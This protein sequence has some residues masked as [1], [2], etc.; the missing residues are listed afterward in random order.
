M[1]QVT[2]P[3]ISLPTHLPGGAPRGSRA[4]SRSWPPPRSRSCSRSAGAP[5]RT[6]AHSTPRLSRASAPAAV[7]RRA[8]WPRPSARARRAGR[9]RAARSIDLGR[10]TDPPE[11]ARGGPGLGQDEARALA[12]VA[13][14]HNPAVP[15]KRCLALAALALALAPAAHAAQPPPGW[16]PHVDSA[17]DYAGGRAGTV[18]FAVRT[19]HRVWGRDARRAVPAASVLKV[20]LL[21]AY[22]RRA[23]VRG[24]ALRPPT[25]RSSR[26]WCAG[27][28]TWP[29]RGCAAS[30]ATPASCGSPA[31][32]ECAASARHAGLGPLERRR[33]RSE[34]LP[35][36]RRAAGAAAPPAHRPAACSARSCPRSAGGSRACAAPDGRSTSRAAGAR[37][38]ARWTTRWR[39]CAAAGRRLVGGDHDHLEPE[40]RLRRSA[41]SRA[42]R[43]ACCAASARFDSRGSGGRAR[44]RRHGSHA[45]AVRRGLPRRAPGLARR[46]PSG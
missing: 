46:Q 25:A 2:Q 12:L 40:P 16:E 5:L 23:E 35:A 45:V 36:A 15:V 43:A 17:A 9:T 18:S 37:A 42:W 29:P 8:A 31:G 30:W 22:L 11:A 21:V 32:P 41:R 27:P 28:T 3:R 33:L 4:S 44:V 1:S 24:R 13:P 14:P 38:A 10:S 7:R 20:M 26:R 19:E 34:P 39:C 6:R